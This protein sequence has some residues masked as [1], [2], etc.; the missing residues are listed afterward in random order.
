MYFTAKKYGVATPKACFPQSIDDVKEYA[1]NVAFPIMLK[2]ISSSA[3][4]GGKFIARTEKELF[5]LYARYE[6]PLNPNFML[7]EYIPGG[8]DSV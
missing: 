8:E 6:D 2:G 4:A 5:D 3:R 7:Q 1:A